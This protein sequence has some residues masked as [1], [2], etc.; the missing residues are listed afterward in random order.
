MKKAS[1]L[2]CADCSVRSCMAGDESRYPDFCLTKNV[3]KELLSEA[4]QEYLSDE[5]NQ[6]LF[7]TSAEIESE[8]YMKYTRVE[9]TICFIE[10]M[11]FKKVGIACCVGLLP[12]TRIFAKLLAAHGI[13]H[14]VCACKIGAVDKKEAGVPEHARINRDES[15]H[16]SM[17]NPIMQAK[18][19]ARAGCDFNVVIG[20][21]V[22]HDSLFLKYSE[23]PATVMIVKDRVLGHNPVQAIYL[24]N[25]TM[26]RFKKEL[27]L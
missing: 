19:L 17:C 4:V 10:R 13:D 18:E 12:E 8:F 2:S 27:G 26:S 20:L 22:G 21:C 25:S 11:G 3:D 6:R 16:E 23:V 14:Y 15:R 5:E 7:V 24:A 1:C 9:E